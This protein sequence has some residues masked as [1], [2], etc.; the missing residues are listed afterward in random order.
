[1]NKLPIFLPNALDLTRA[2]HY[3]ERANSSRQFSNFGPLYQEFAARLAAYFGVEENELVLTSN[4][5]VA[6]EAAIAAEG[7]ASSHWHLPAWS[8]AATGTA[9]L[10]SGKTFSFVD[11]S[12]ENG[13]IQEPKDSE[14]SLAVTPFGASLD[15]LNG[16]QYRLID[17]AASF[18]GLKDVGSKLTNRTGIVVSLHATKALSSGEG[19]VIISRDTDWIMRIKDFIRFGF[20]EGSRISTSV[21]TNGKMSEITAAFGLSALDGWA[22]LRDS[23]MASV[24]SARAMSREFDMPVIGGMSQNLVTPYWV[25]RLASKTDVFS[26]ENSLNAAQIPFRHWW[27]RGMHQMPAFRRSEA[28]HHLPNTDSWAQTTLGLPFF[29][30]MTEQ[31]FGLIHDC[32]EA[33][34]A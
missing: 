15:I 4:A 32:L 30:E 1:M 31:Q 14:L 17:A 20:E 18:D 8:F 10:R 13:V 21:G 6:L 25:V 27:E 3:L 24:A 19:G 28:P 26:L 5:T 23:W 2:T 9:A 34:F 12:M 22:E 7:G 33:H 29:A 11:V 16:D